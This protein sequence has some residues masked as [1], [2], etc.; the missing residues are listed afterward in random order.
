M[1][2]ANHYPIITIDH[3]RE[4]ERK[5]RSK[6]QKFVEL[7]PSCRNE[8]NK[9]LSLYHSW[10]TIQDAV[11]NQRKKCFIEKHQGCNVKEPF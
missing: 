4:R 1:S 9:N 7:C 11:R 10:Q 3:A 6:R 8:F 5:R 2:G